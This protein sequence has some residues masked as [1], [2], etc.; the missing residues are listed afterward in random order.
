MAYATLPPL[1]CGESTPLPLA[2]VIGATPFSHNEPERNPVIEK[3]C[4]G[5]SGHTI[6]QIFHACSTEAA[7]GEGQAAGQLQQLLAG[8]R[9]TP[10]RVIAAGGQAAARHT[11][12]PLSRAA[13]QIALP[14]QTRKESRVASG[15]GPRQTPHW[16][17]PAKQ[18]WLLLRA[19]GAPHQQGRWRCQLGGRLGRAS[20]RRHPPPAKADLAPAAA[21]MG[22]EVERQQAISVS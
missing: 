16:F 5:C 4:G 1:P 20:L 3:V 11:R 18:R 12:L 13:H 9:C 7:G 10:P 17:R 22:G 19:A 15:R 6:G 14:R 8:G 2:A 21:A